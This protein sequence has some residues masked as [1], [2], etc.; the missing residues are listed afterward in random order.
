L[1]LQRSHLLVLGAG[2]AGSVLALKLAR[3]SPPPEWL[4]G[5]LVYE[6]R[7]VYDKACG[8]ATP[9]ELL[10][11]LEAHGLPL[12]P[13]VSKVTRFLV[14]VSAR[15]VRLLEFSNPVWVVIDKRSWV[16]AMRGRVED[17]IA[18]KLPRQLGDQLVVDARGPWG[19]RGAKL[20]VWQA[21]ATV[22][23]WDEEL[24]AMSFEL[25]GETGMA[26]VFPRGSGLVNVGAGFLGVPRPRERGVK[27]VR[28]LVR[29]AG[30]ELES[31]VEERYAPLTLMPRISLGQGSKRIAVG[32]AAGLVL[33]LG[34]E[35]IR[36]AAISAIAAAEALTEVDKP[37]A[38]QV[39]RVMESKLSKLVSQVKLHSLLLSLT[40][41]LDGLGARVLS[42]ASEAWYLRWLTGRLP[43]YTPFYLLARLIV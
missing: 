7:P 43:L 21:Y 42:R 41:K 36:P 30:A 11:I 18:S 35:G 13:V 19:S 28:D 6:P 20:V 34:G 27:L 23:G 25:T 22:K 37:D 24:A 26:W 5:L 40:R 1:L 15:P 14:A 32:E 12:P 10:E 2:V 31:I 39:A 8:E 3:L 16:E 17:L 29:A 38:A 33:S 4:E 9:L